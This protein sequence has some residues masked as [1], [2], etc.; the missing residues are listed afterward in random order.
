L[1]EAAGTWFWWGAKGSGPC[2]ALWKLM[3]NRFVNVHG[4]NNLIW[5]WTS[6]V[7]SDAADWYPG[8]AYVDV[9]GMD[10][11]PGENQHHTQYFVYNKIREIF[12]GRKLI[13]LSECGSVPDPA[14]MVSYGDMWSYFMPWNGDFTRSDAHNGAA[15]WN[16]LFSYDYVVT[17]DKM[18]NL[19]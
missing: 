7:A 17:R 3:F 8:D 16:T 5:V 2:K 12:G 18:P 4:L 14:Q 11:Y 10:I 13:T 9:I 15:W 1:H 19:K 6:D